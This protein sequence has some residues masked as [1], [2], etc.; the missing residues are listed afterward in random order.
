MVR[1]VPRW[2]PHGLLFSGEAR[3]SNN[4]SERGYAM[5]TT[6]HG[7][8]TPQQKDCHDYLTTIFA[9]NSLLEFRL[10]SPT[11]K[12]YPINLWVALEDAC[13]CGE[14]V[15]VWRR[16]YEFSRD[17]DP[18]YGDMYV[19]YTPDT[20]QQL[21]F[22]DYLCQKN[23]E[24]YNIFTGMVARKYINGSLAKDAVD[25]I[26]IVWADFDDVE[27]LNSY[28]A[29]AGTPEALAPSL[30]TC[31]GNGYHVYWRLSEPI[32]HKQFRSFQQRLADKFG[33]DCSIKD[34]ARLDR[35]PGFTNYK[36]DKEPKRAFVQTPPTG[37]SYTIS[38]IQKFI[39][40]DTEALSVIPDDFEAKAPRKRNRNTTGQTTWG[41]VSA[42]YWGD[43]K[44]GTPIVH[45]RPHMLMSI[46]GYLRQKGL[47][48]DEVR[49]ILKTA[50][51]PHVDRS[52]GSRNYNDVDEW[53]TYYADQTRQ[54][55][56]TPVEFRQTTAEGSKTGTI[57]AADYSPKQVPW[58]WPEILPQ[59][60]LT[61]LVSEEGVGKSTLAAWIAST[62]TTGGQWPN[63][64]KAEQGRVIWL[65]A[66][67]SP[68]YVLVPRFIVNK[69]E[70]GRILLPESV[71]QLDELC[72]MYPDV[73]LI[74]LDPI[75]S[76]IAGNENSNVEVR[77]GL[78]PLVELAEKHNVAILG[79]SHLSKKVDL[80]LIN[81]TLGSRAWSAVPRMTWT[82][83]R[84][85]DEM[86]DDNERLL[87]NVK[88]NLGPKPQGLKY[89]I[90]AD[91]KF[92]DVGVVQWSND[93]VNYDPDA[94]G[95]Q[96]RN[97]L[98]DDCVTWIGEYLKEHGACSSKQLIADGEIAGFKQRMIWEA[99]KRA[100][101]Q[102]HRRGG[103]AGSGEWIWSLRSE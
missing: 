83:V 65:S 76:Y 31:S 5:S 24:G 30:V 39:G 85:T 74:V 40:V 19:T 6:E 96:D 72:S 81:R 53:A 22:S 3:R 21:V 12:L 7:G 67:E 62:I 36:R 69:A 4:P 86:T 34:A 26:W 102:A 50:V 103:F 20:P 90:E 80:K 57:S 43:W 37:H 33:S 75:T 89:T 63:D 38:E 8:I 23:A 58:L 14:Q 2:I 16:E 32:T 71:G 93:R 35:V 94:K 11:P 29:Q 87:V 97:F 55:T 13:R 45:P 15:N 88:N 59:G 9:P 25:S 51:A 1:G 47:R 41:D 27:S 64:G 95:E 82:V 84:P 100:G 54:Y 44:V 79:L 18:D 70:L 52:Q 42:V 46:A 56:Y 98:I 73:R 66:E 60:M 99:K 61:M 78:K 77:A 17:P 68:E 48:I 49:W 10:E 91:E 92:P 28:K 101:V